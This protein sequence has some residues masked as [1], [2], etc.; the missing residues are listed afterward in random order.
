M[1]PP[2]RHLHGADRR[3]GGGRA[4]RPLGAPARRAARRGCGRGLGR[5][6]QPALAAADRACAAGGAG[7]PRAGSSVFGA[8][9][10]SVPAHDL[11]ALCDVLAE[12]ACS[13]DPA[14]AGLFDTGQPLL[15]ARAPGRLDVMGGFADYSG[16]LTL[17]LPLREAAYVAVQRRSEPWVEVV[18]AGFGPCAGPRR[19][20]RFEL[21]ELERHC[22]SYA[23]AREYFA[24]DPRRAWAAYV[25]GALVALRVEL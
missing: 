4:H 6:C 12:C 18:S 20:A 10:V 23:D 1:L 7:A 19:H 8:Y 17:E 2:L 22:R 14:I 13:G 9:A 15:L 24:R 3:R 25:L 16:S 11:N 5:L 21:G